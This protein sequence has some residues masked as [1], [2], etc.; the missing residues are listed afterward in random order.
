MSKISLLARIGVDATMG[1]P[2]AMICTSEKVSSQH[3]AV[4]LSQL[5]P[6]LNR[7][8]VVGRGT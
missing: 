3:G 8:F 6:R 4:V 2:F 5:S 7:V 1:T